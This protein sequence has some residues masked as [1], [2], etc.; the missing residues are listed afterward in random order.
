MRPA[1]P[2]VAYYGWLYWR[3]PLKAALATAVGLG[4]LG[5]LPVGEAARILSID[6]AFMAACCACAMLGVLLEV[7]QD[8]VGFPRWLY[9]LPV[10]TR[11]LVFWP[12]LLG[13]AGP[14]LAWV[15]LAILFNHFYS[16]GLW[17]TAPALGVAVGVTWLQAA[18]WGAF[19][20]PLVKGLAVLA[21]M[22]LPGAFAGWLCVGSGLPEHAAAAALAA[23][24]AASYFAALAGVDRDRRGDTWPSGPA[25]SRRPGSV[26]R[27]PA[28]PRRPFGSPARAQ[29]WYELHGPR[30]LAALL[31]CGIAWIPLALAIFLGLLKP[32]RDLHLLAFFVGAEIPIVFGLTMAY[33]STR[34]DRNLA[35]VTS[36][37]DFMLLRPVT[38]GRLAAAYFQTWL[39]A[40]VLSLLTWLAGVAA[41]GLC[42]GAFSAAPGRLLRGLAVYLGQ[43]S[44]W[45]TSGV[46]ALSAVTLV[47]ITWRFASGNWTSA[48]FGGSRHRTGFAL[49]IANGVLDGL[50]AV[51]VSLLINPATRAWGVETF[52]RLGLV[53]LC[54]K[55]VVAF[56]AFRL[57]RE[58]GLLDGSAARLLLPTWILLA[59]LVVGLTAAVVPG[60]GLPVPTSFV[61]LWTVILLP[62]GRFALLP[63]GLDAWRHR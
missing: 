8:R 41:A 49:V 48:I 39:F 47:G 23:C 14:G 10:P 11:T 9:R 18:F 54:V 1:F 37:I 46:A 52:A 42:W 4:V 44:A 50:V 3:N 51:G 31:L 36:V 62:L 35:A 7:D 21:G 19:R 61:L 56:V 63:L 5:L 60:L 12:W 26:R 55:A 38:C 58:R 59:G 53:V 34:T 22:A 13:A 15:F 45:Q 40:A 25:P 27:R 57:A 30:G 28:P 29:W 33:A 6:F 20:A 43:F 17:V 24:L 16:A 2:G 32:D